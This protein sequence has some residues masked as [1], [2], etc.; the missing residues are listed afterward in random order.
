[1]TAE[2][3]SSI[4]MED[5]EEEEGVRGSGDKRI[6]P[7]LG[8]PARSGHV[9]PVPSALPGLAPA[10]QMTF[11]ACVRHRC[12]AHLEGSLQP[13]GR[14]DDGLSGKCDPCQHGWGGSAL[15]EGVNSTTPSCVR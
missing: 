15:Q 1:M 7:D 12:G 13:C 14:A 6:R 9:R 2:A 3:S 10:S 11:A 8:Q 4:Q 5:E